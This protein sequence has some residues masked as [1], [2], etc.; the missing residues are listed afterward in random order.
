MGRNVVG[1]NHS[2]I[3]A[4]TRAVALDD[5]EKSVATDGGRPLR[6]AGQIDA[7]RAPQRSATLFSQ[8]NRRT[9]AL[10][11]KICV[12]RHTV[13]VAILINVASAGTNY[14]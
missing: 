2:P 6:H 12:R 8:M 10:S 9:D 5:P 14:G 3:S 1:N 4:I 7:L 13:F 11:A